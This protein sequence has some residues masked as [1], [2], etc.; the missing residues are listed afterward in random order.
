MTRPAS[1]GRFFVRTTGLPR[2]K[3]RTHPTAAGSWFTRTHPGCYRPTMR[4]LP[5]LLVVAGCAAPVAKPGTVV[6]AS[7][8]ALIRIQRVGA[9]LAMENV[10]LCD[11]TIGVVPLVTSGVYSPTSGPD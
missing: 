11:K 8:E 2:H 6:D 4:F 3:T 1:A 10:R 7:G 5:V 9:A